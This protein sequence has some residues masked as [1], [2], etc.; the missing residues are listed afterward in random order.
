[1]IN[2]WALRLLATAALGLVGGL[3][4]VLPAN[5]QGAGPFAGKSISAVVNYQVKGRRG[6][7]DFDA[8]MKFDLNLSVS[9]DG[10]VTGNAARSSEGRRGPIATSRGISATIGK[11][12]EIAGSGNSVIVVSGNTMTILRT[13]EVGGAKITI[14]L[15][16]G[17]RCSITA[18]VVREVGAG[19]TKRDHIAGGTAEIFSARQVSSSCSVR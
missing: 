9:G 3:P 15:Q 6:G 5:A 8:P 14:N 10:A 16:G 19:T 7:I 13:F 12:R 1:M 2:L 18:P 4:A 11:P 17:G